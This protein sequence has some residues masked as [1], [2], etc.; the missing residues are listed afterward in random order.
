M[1]ASQY[2]PLHRVEEASTAAAACGEEGLSSS[3]ITSAAQG[4][5]QDAEAEDDLHEAGPSHA[6][7][8]SCRTAIGDFLDRP[9]SSLGAQVIHYFLMIVILASTLCVIV[10][11]VP[12]YQQNAAFFPAE[13]CFTALFT[14]EF[15]LR[16][17]ASGDSLQEFATNGYNAIDFLAIFPGY[18]EL[19]G[20]FLHPSG[21]ESTMSEVSKAASSMRS[22]R[23]VRIV[24][25]V[26]VFRVMRLAKVARHSQLLSIIFMVFVKVSQSGLVVVLMLVCFA[27]ILSSSL[28]YLFENE[29]CEQTGSECIG[30]NAF[31]SIPASFWWSISTLTTVGYGDMVPHSNGGKVIGAMTATT[32]LL[33]VAISIALVSLNFKECFIEEKA[34]SDLRRKHNSPS[35]MGD[36]RLQDGKEVDDRLKVFE[37]CSFALLERL[38]VISERQEEKAQLLPMLDVLSSHAEGLVSDVKVFKSSVLKGSPSNPRTEELVGSRSE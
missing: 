27:M 12:E 10:E 30:P 26:R 36:V 21:Q 19:L 14:A 6:G 9:E 37:D 32:G 7:S 38:R 13:V 4:G 1:A 16:L 5:G 20:I 29:H 8:D 17:Y 3:L 2:Q 15:A 22:L 11:T 35:K 24:R 25:M 28:V 33:V 23:M 18:M 31:V 34:K